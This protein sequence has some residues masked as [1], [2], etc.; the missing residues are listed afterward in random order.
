MSGCIVVGVDDNIGD[1]S[2]LFLFCVVCDRVLSVFGRVVGL[3]KSSKNCL[4]CCI[5][6][7]LLLSSIGVDDISG[8][9][10]GFCIVGCCMVIWFRGSVNILLCECAYVG[11]LLFL[12]VISLSLVSGI[13]C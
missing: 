13:L 2:V 4:P 12:N 8:V 5:F 6:C 10:F 1:G 7:S 3:F 11:V 9:L